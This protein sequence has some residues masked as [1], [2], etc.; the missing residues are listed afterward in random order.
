MFY[1]DYW[2]K[3]SERSAQGGFMVKHR[4]K[5]V[6][7]VVHSVVLRV[8]C[9]VFLRFYLIRE[10]F[11]YRALRKFGG[12]SILDIGCGEGSL[13]LT[14]FGSVVGVDLARQPLMFCKGKYHHVVCA[15]ALFLP[16]RDGCFD[17]VNSTDFIGHIRVKD[18]SLLFGEMCRVLAMGGYSSHIIE[19][20]SSD[21]VYGY[22]KNYPMEYGKALVSIGGHVGLETCENTV[23]R[24]QE[25]FKVV[26]IEKAYG[27]ILETEQLFI[28]LSPCS[29]FSGT[30]NLISYLCERSITNLP[31]RFA[32]NIF[33]SMLSFIEIHF[34]S[35]DKINGLLVVVKK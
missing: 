3:R 34:A 18:K 16:F 10:I 35:Y 25:Y 31:I 14:E 28:L 21:L 17:F 7:L 11:I 6:W 8:L 20:D 22:I 5:V 4:D 26:C 23:K 12:S 32:I 19:T 9:S 29:K 1:D 27:S 24:F 33:L 15:S 2:V 30:V 13:F